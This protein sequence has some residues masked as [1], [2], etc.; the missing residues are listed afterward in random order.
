MK[1]KVFASL[2]IGAMA[3]AALSGCSSSGN[4]TETSEPAKTEAV[5]E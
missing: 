5:S 3:A 1:K 2:L 4:K